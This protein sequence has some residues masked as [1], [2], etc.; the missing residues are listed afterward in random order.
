M[1][2]MNHP[3][4]NSTVLA[5]FAGVSLVFSTCAF[6]AG[7]TKHKGHHAHEH[8]HAELSLVVEGTK[9]TARLEVPAES[10]YGFEY[11]A[12]TDADKKKRDAGCEKLKTNFGAMVA[13]DPAYG[14]TFTN[15]SLEPRAAGHAGDHGE[16]HAEFEATCQKPPSG[17]NV[18]IAF[19]KF[20]PRVK[21]IKVQVLSGEKQSGADIQGGKGSAKL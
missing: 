9:L 2:T 13:V 1:A 15:K 4:L 3:R 17:A 7:K 12:K 19:D 6:A 8:G 16:T 21:K 18:D 20:F 11:E 5:G 10:I 14:C